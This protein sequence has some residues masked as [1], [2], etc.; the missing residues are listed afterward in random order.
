M[1]PPLGGCRVASSGGRSGSQV[2]ADQLRLRLR[3]CYEF[4]TEA[5]IADMVADPP[6]LLRLGSDAHVFLVLALTARLSRLTE[7]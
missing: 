6:A 1:G 4:Q 2:R 7:Y 3:W 5:P